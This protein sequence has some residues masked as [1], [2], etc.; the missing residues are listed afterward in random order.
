MKV[1]ASDIKLHSFKRVYLL[2]GEEVYLRKTYKGKL[3]EAITAGDDMNV[4]YLEGKGIDFIKV[5]DFAQT[6]PFFAEYRLVILENTGLF[7]SAGEE[8]T[9]WIEKLP[10]T[11]VLI[12]VEEKADKRSKLYKTIN[13]TGYACEM[14]KPSESELTRWILQILKKNGKQITQPACEALLM[15]AGDNMENL[16]S[17]LD[18]LVCYTGTEQG[19]TIQDVEAICTEQ[20]TNQIFRM[21]DA[22]AEGSQEL[23]LKLY[24]DM[25]ALKEPSMRILYLIGRQF[26]QLLAVREMVSERKGR[27]EIASGLK[28]MPFIAAKMMKQ[29]RAFSIQQLRE[30]VELCVKQE[31]L[32]KTGYLDEKIAVEMTMIRICKRKTGSCLA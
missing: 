5:R 28:I 32:V 1:I 21:I 25:L 30:F 17:E 8:W 3:R 23:A 19:I 20:V 16:E 29:S 31:E 14:K 26:N 27:D 13:K 15:R 10:E 4:L 11:S 7:G 9:E 18:K 12:F 2:Y 6:M 24:Y 22:C